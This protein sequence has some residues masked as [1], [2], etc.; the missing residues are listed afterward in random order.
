MEEITTVSTLRR[1]GFCSLRAAR[2]EERVLTQPL[3]FSGATLFVNAHCAS[4]AE[5][6]ANCSAGY[7]QAALLEAPPGSNT[8]AEVEVEGFRRSE[9]LP[10][11][12]DALEG[13]L[14]WRSGRS[15]A[16]AGTARLALYLRSCDLYS[17]WSE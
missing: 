8:S 5:G 13:A 16:D 6:A 7:V 4:C 10:V 17:F 1:D 9:A 2:G 14:R 12:G 15:V 11:T 3:R